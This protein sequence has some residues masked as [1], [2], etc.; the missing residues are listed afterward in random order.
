MR[1]MEDAGLVRQSSKSAG[2]MRATERWSG[3]LEDDPV[4][5]QLAE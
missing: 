1:E 3:Q 4:T 2:K 5:I